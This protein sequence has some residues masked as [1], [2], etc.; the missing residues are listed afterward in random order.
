MY[1]RHTEIPTLDVR[2]GWLVEARYFNQV[3]R[4][5][6]RLG[7]EIRLSPSGL[8]QLDLILQRDAWIVV[9]RVLNDM[10]VVAW[11][12]FHSRG[13]R[14]LH[15]PVACELLLF[16]A[17]ASMVMNRTLSAMEAEL[18]AAIAEAAPP[19]SL[20]KVLPFHPRSC[21]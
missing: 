21:A 7:P 3:R 16:H 9:D 8:K 13:R 10:P 12:A 17:M 18:S 14:S 1:S 20:G 4:A 15:R 19:P 5:L 11:T 6:A 2:P